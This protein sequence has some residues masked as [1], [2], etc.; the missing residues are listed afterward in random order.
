ML[1]REECSTIKSLQDWKASNFLFKHQE[2]ERQMSPSVWSISSC[3]L[4][5]FSS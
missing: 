3:G 2:K 1:G 5:I 4:E